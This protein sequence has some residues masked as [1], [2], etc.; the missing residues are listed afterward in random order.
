MSYSAA[1]FERKMQR[2]VLKRSFVHILREF[3]EEWF[4]G[5]MHPEPELIRNNV[6]HDT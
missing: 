4:F 1:R 5:E 3:F 6:A 2:A